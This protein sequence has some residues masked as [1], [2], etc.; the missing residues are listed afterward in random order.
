[1]IY[2]DAEIKCKIKNLLSKNKLETEIVEYKEAKSSFSF[3][4]IGKYFSALSN[5]ANVRG[6]RE[7]W[8]IFGVNN[9]AQIV[10]TNFR[11]D[12]TLQNLK[13]EIAA[14]T[15]ERLTFLEIYEVEIDKMRVIAFQIPPAVRGIPTTWYGATYGRE[16]EHLSPLPLNK[17]DLIRAQI[18]IDWSSNIVRG[19]KWDD[20][21][22]RAVEYAVNVFLEKQKAVGGS[23]E[24]L[25]DLDRRDTL[26]K[27]GVLMDGEI[28]NTALLL[29]GKEESFRFFDGFFPRIT[30][31]L[32]GS[33]GLVKAY[34]HIDMPMIFA[35]DR[36]YN[37][38][39]N[40]LYRYIPGEGTLFP[41]VVKSY[42][43]DVVKEILNNC[44][45]H[46]NYQ[47]RGKINVLEYED[48]LVFMN[49]GDFIPE[50]V[51]RTLE[52]GYRPPYY[53]NP[54]LCKAMVSLNMIDT[55]SMGIPMMYQI[56]R[57]KYFPLPSYDLETPNRVKVTLY[58]KVLSQ[59]YTR[60]LHANEDLDLRTV[61]LLDKIQK[62]EAIS[63]ADYAELKKRGL[64]EGRYPNIFV[65]YKVADMVGEQS[66]YIRNSGLDDDI[67]REFVLKAVTTFGEAKLSEITDAVKGILPAQLDEKQRL[68]KI[69]N[70]LQQLKSKEL[71]ESTGAR[72]AAL[73]RP[74]KK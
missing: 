68:R 44:I 1:M 40:E 74:S 19:A 49:E 22:P 59:S 24:C 11:P 72:K 43:E 25:S 63:K 2:T 47:L 37:K 51:E 45:A 67:I 71:I 27:A 18:G 21:D 57:Q 10:N 12:G 41:D 9:K 53:R 65:S 69:S 26:N 7:A 35:V 38:I 30:W 20:L 73:W 6:S 33:N 28:T 3:K 31:S 56:Q 5:E 46:S 62:K 64:A 17:L 61:F 70:I 54:F 15:N 14:N 34:E 29:L 23:N 52:A 36:T 55:N 16:G 60:L 48:K 42:N 66:E 4:D 50:T 58:G 39:R 8:L 32:Y 13:K